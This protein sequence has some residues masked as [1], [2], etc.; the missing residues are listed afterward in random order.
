MQFPTVSICN[1]NPLTTQYAA[2]LTASVLESEFNLINVRNRDLSPADEYYITWANRLAMTK[3][4]TNFTQEQKT[5]LG[6][7]GIL[8]RCWM[9]VAEDCNTNFTSYFDITY[10]N[11]IR[12]N[13][14]KNSNGDNVPLMKN[15]KAGSKSG[16]Q[17]FMYLPASVNRYSNVVYEGL[18]VFIHNSSFDPLEAESVEV[19]TG[20][21]TNIAIKRTFVSKQPD[22]Y[23][24]CVDLA[25]FDSVLYRYFDA[26]NKTYRQQDCIELC[27]QKNIIENCNCYSLNYPRLFNASACLTIDKMKCSINQYNTFA[28]KDI[29]QDCMDQCPLECESVSYDLTLSS[30]DYPSQFMYDQYKS[31]FPQITSYDLF[32]KSAVS[33]NV[34][35]SMLAYTQLTEIKKTEV[36]D[37]F[38]NIGGTLGLYIGI[39][40][41]SLIE[42]VEIVFEVLLVLFYKEG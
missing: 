40:F 32:K 18:S 26:N 10:G 15:Y 27:I 20:K 13:G 39:S 9:N 1:V 25:N 29:S 31:M 36:I 19:S 34:Y 41:L 6:S 17:I 11:C 21:Q 7:G 12:I 8:V 28:A 35:Y 30:S 23:S 37:L 22:P 2:D 33:L 4:V 42:L 16:L 24:S 14:G 5:Q 3:A 38:S